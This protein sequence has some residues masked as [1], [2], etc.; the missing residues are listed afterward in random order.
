MK[1]VIVR[2]YEGIRSLF[3]TREKVYKGCGMVD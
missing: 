3:I 2:I 1:K